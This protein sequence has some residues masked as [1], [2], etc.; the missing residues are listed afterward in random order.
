MAEY[1]SAY[2]GEQIDAGIGKANTAVQP[3][4]LNS[5]LAGKQNTLI[6]GTNIKTINDQSLL[7]SGNITIQ[8]GGGDGASIRIID[9]SDPTDWGEE[10][11]TQSC[12]LDI[13]T[14]EY[15]ILYITNIPS[16]VDGMNYG[17]SMILNAKV[18]VDSPG[19]ELYMRQY[20]R[21][22]EGDEENPEIQS[23]NFSKEGS[24]DAE[25]EV[26]SYPIGGGDSEE[27][28]IYTQAYSAY[29][30]STTGQEEF[31]VYSN[32]LGEIS[33]AIDAYKEVVFRIDGP[34]YDDTMYY[35]IS[36]YD[37]NGRQYIEDWGIGVYL[38]S[39][40]CETPYGQYYA[41]C[42]RVEQ[43]VDYAVYKITKGTKRYVPTD[44]KFATNMITFD[45]DDSNQIWSQKRQAFTVDIK[46]TS[47]DDPVWVSFTKASED[48]VNEKI[49]YTSNII[50]SSAH[51]FV[52]EL[53]VEYINGGV[54][55]SIY[56][57]ELTATAQ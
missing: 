13:L 55:T 7:G 33:D 25:M 23:F 4:D 19:N 18:D 47:G 41:E 57:Y 51:A 24:G 34:N 49:I 35:R 42:D 46:E 37:R 54:E 16:D 12:L 53:I 45:S 38:P 29:V 39:F 10:G 22:D 6:S 48:T 52:Y 2:T 3:A 43:G 5:A 27:A 26:E 21:H 28:P 56:R 32:T 44:I 30:N 11:P 31:L 8:G 20:I 40:I 36:N 50:F 1:K 17:L 15:Q 14:N 9:A